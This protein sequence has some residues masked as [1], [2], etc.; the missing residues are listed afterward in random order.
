MLGLS[1][2]L[3]QKSQSIRADILGEVENKPRFEHLYKDEFT[4][5]MARAHGVSNAYLISEPSNQDLLDLIYTWTCKFE[6][7]RVDMQ[8]MI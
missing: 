7:D 8:V 1:E 2:V 6:E 3:S 5:T 4:T